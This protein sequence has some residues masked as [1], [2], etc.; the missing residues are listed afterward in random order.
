MLESLG[1]AF[2]RERYAT[3]LAR[4]L[5]L[6]LEEKTVL[7]QEVHHRVKNNMAVVASLLGL[8]AAAAASEETASQLRTSQQRIYSMA[9]IHEQ[10]YGSE[11][12]KYIRFDEYVMQLVSE[13]RASYSSPQGPRIELNLERVELGIGQALPCGL[14]LNEWVTNALKHA[15]PGDR[16]GVIAVTFTTARPGFFEMT[17]QDDGVGLPDDFRLEDAPSLGLRIV[18]LLAAQLSGTFEAHGGTGS[19]FSLT[20]PVSGGADSEF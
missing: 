13:L 11:S 14:I 5:K 17:V 4:K 1:Q 12:L 9:S 6:A 3:V 8:Q 16:L 18:Q 2:V 19:R 7:L 15:F 10:L 20:F